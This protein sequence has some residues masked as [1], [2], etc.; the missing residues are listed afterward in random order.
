MLNKLIH[1]HEG[2]LIRLGFVILLIINISL[3]WRWCPLVLHKS[4]SIRVGFPSV[5]HSSRE[6]RVLGS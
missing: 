3:L 4:R 5:F 6:I 2:T 1:V